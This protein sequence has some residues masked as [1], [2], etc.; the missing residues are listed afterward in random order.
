MPTKAALSSAAHEQRDGEAVRRDA[1]VAGADAVAAH[2]EDPVAVAREVQDEPDD[3]R[4]RRSTRTA[5]PGTCR[6]HSRRTAAWRPGPLRSATL[7]LPV[8][9]TERPSVR[10]AS[11]NSVARVTTKDGTLVRITSSPL[12]K[13]TAEAK[14]ERREDPDDDRRIV[15]ARDDGN[16][17]R[18]G[19]DHR[20]DRE[21]EVAGDHQQPHRECDDAEL[22]G[23]VEPARGP[24][25]RQEIGPAEDREEDQDGDHADQRARPRA[26]ARERRSKARNRA[27]LAMQ[28]PPWMVG[29]MRSRFHGKILGV[30]QHGT[31]G[32]ELRLSAARRGMSGPRMQS[33]G[34]TF[35]RC[36][37][38]G[39]RPPR[40]PASRRRWRRRRS[41]VRSAP[42]SSGGRARS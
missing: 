42:V 15:V 23:D 41:P 31:V 36:G 37:V 7:V 17:H 5:S 35:G 6:R 18:A 29:L 25:G 40:R 21:I 8:R 32:A 26:G 3:Q 30:V 33:S 20:A 14:A 24:A 28:P 4:R 34:R 19:G 16:G 1:G 39:R 12:M 10:P 11:A 9:M 2:G 13:P 22:G 38:S 27:R